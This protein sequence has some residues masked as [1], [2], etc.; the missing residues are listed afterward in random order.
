MKGLSSPVL[1][2]ITCGAPVYANALA[3]PF[4]FDDGHLIEDNADIRQLWPPRWVQ[5]SAAGHA[6]INSHPLTSLTPALNYAID[7][8]AVEGYH[9]VNFSLHIA[10]AVALARGNRWGFVGA[11]ACM[12]LAPTSSFVPLVNEVGAERRMYLP[13]AA[14]L[15]GSVAAGAVLGRH[16]RWGRSAG[17]VLVALLAAVLSGLTRARNVDYASEI[18]LWQTAVAAVPDNPRAHFNLANRLKEAGAGAEAE[19]HYRRSLAL[20]PDQIGAHYNLGIALERT[21]RLDQAWSTIAQRL[22]RTPPWPEP[23]CAWAW[24]IRRRSNW[25]QPHSACATS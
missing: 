17:W 10:S 15:G 1:I 16:W 13:R 2:L 22:R 23:N 12:V 25:R 6:A 9:L 11:L 7:E 18:A 20:D 8:L 5:P 21:G 14:L 24:R 19:V 4:I 3:G